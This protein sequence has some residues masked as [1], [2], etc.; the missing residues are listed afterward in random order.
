MQT[1]DY[2]LEIETWPSGALV[3][4]SPDVRGLLVVA[5]DEVELR[6][7]ADEAV[8]L[9]RQAEAEKECDR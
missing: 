4:T 1:Q 8:R 9:L 6:R 7:R 5:G 3:G 2:R